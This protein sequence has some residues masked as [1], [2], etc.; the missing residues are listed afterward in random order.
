VKL[1][2]YPLVESSDEAPGRFG[3]ELEEMPETEGD[4][5]PRSAFSRFRERARGVFSLDLRSLAVFR[6]AFGLVVLSDLLIRAENIRFFYSD[7]GVLPSWGFTLVSSPSDISLYLANGSWQW[8]AFLL[9]ISMF[10]CAA[11][12]AGYRTR[13][14][15]IVLAILVLSLQR[16]NLL[17]LQGADGVIRSLLFW[18]IF[19]PL[20]DYWSLDAKRKTGAPGGFQFFGTASVCVLVQAVTIYFFAYLMKTHEV[21][22]VHGLA[23][24]YALNVDYLTNANGRYLLQYPSLLR[25]LTFATLALEQFIV[26]LLFVPWFTPWFRMFVVGGFLA[27]HTGTA[28]TMELGPFPYVCMAM[29]LLFLPPVFWERL[30]GKK[31][32]A[33]TSRAEYREAEGFPL[34]PLLNFLLLFFLFNVLLWNRRNLHLEE[35]ERFYPSKYDFILNIPGLDQNWGMFSPYPLNWDGWFLI[36]G[37]T[38]GGRVLNLSPGAK[39]DDPINEERPAEIWKTFAN[40]RMRKYYMSLA[41]YSSLPWRQYYIRAAALEFAHSHPGEALAELDV[42]FFQEIAQP[43]GTSTKPERIPIWHSNNPAWGA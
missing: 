10:V 1:E 2:K 5:Y 30:L 8:A 37:K 14:S 40:E 17:V 38:K 23:L 42:V 4:G 9:A 32:G 28:L 36:T 18:S 29:W 11:F 3:L 43:D 24:Q 16:R 7:E 13:E 6:V 20:G 19:L 15:N 21:W 27:F 34:A 26:F 31:P 41:S 22:R 25:F 12:I 39:L 35:K 33:H